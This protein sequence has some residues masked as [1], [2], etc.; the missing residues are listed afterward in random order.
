MQHFIPYCMIGDFNTK[1]RDWCS[2]D[3]TSFEGLKLD[4][5]TS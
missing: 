1:S 3:M 5:L 4:F 2:N